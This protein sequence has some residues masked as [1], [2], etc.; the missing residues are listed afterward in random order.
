MKFLLDKG[1]NASKASLRHRFAHLAA[2]LGYGSSGLDA[3]PALV[4]A[5]KNGHYDIV[6]LIL[7]HGVDVDNTSW[8]DGYTAL[9]KAAKEGH[10]AI[11]RLLLDRGAA[12]EGNADLRVTQKKT[13]LFI[14][15]LRGHE[16]IVGLLLERGATVDVRVDYRHEI[17]FRDMTRV[18]PLMM[19][20]WYWPDKLRLLQLLLDTGA[21]INA[22]SSDGDTALSFAASTHGSSRTVRY[23]LGRGANF[24]EQAGADTMTLPRMIAES[25]TDSIDLQERDIDSTNPQAGLSVIRGSIRWIR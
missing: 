17:T 21:D 7:D 5:A 19:A 8:V 2:N 14:A 23:L 12:V 11:V 1:A 9:F 22:K 18:T 15:V 3:D 24:D 10:E 25:D 20:A 16:T 6:K 13:P 4:R